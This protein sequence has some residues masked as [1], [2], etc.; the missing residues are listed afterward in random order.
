MAVFQTKKSK[1]I[2]ISV[3]VALI[4]AVGLTIFLISLPSEDISP[5]EVYTFEDYEYVI[6]EDGMIEIVAYLGED[7]EVHMPS[8]IDSR[9]VTSI[10]EGVFYGDKSVG[11]VYLGSSVT[12]IG[13]AA[14]YGCTALKTVYFTGNIPRFDEP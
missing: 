7:A 6:L 12:S 8:F 13:K 11:A 5:R 9:A 3:I 2:L 1:I 14:F 10:G 4:I